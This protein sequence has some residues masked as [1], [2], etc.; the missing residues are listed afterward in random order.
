MQIFKAQHRYLEDEEYSEQMKN[1]YWMLGAPHE[2][3]VLLD[4][5]MQLNDLKDDIMKD[6]LQC[7][8]LYGSLHIALCLD[9]CERFEPGLK[10]RMAEF[11]KRVAAGKAK[12]NKG[13]SKTANQVQK[14]KAAVAPKPRGVH[15]QTTNKKCAAEQ[16]A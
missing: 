3:F 9:L 1:L 4:S 8:M 6:T 2:M 14:Q 10:H 13:S 11:D 15:K 5:K 16:T 7:D 12:H